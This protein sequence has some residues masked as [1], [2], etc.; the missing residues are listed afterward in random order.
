MKRYLYIL[1]VMLWPLFARAENIS[2][3][4]WCRL[5]DIHAWHSENVDNVKWDPQNAHTD[6]FLSKT[7]KPYFLELVNERNQLAEKNATLS[8]ENSEARARCERLQ[9]ENASL[10]SEYDALRTKN[11]VSFC[12]IIILVVLFG[13][14]TLVPII[15]SIKR[16]TTTPSKSAC[17]E[18]P[19][20][21]SPINFSKKECPNCGTH[22]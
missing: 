21:G 4:A 5:R 19:R 6:A 18:C 17:N 11:N 20:C 14:L 1:A 10:R 3:E 8:S 9:A 13:V 7:I 22:I 2:S 15:C 16:K 12:I